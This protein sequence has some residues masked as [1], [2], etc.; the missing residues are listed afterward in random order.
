MDNEGEEKAGEKSVEESAPAP[1]PS[2]EYFLIPRPNV[3][4]KALLEVLAIVALYILATRLVMSAALAGE[5]L[6]DLFEGPEATIL[7]GFFL[8][9]VVQLIIVV[10]LH[11]AGQVDVRA[12]V[13]SLR[14]K[15]P[16]A[17]WHIALTVA[18]VDI[19]FIIGGWIDEPGRV[20]EFSKFALMGSLVPALDGATQ[21]VIF[22]GFILLRLKR[23]G[24]VGRLPIV[25]SG[26]AFALIHIGY[27]NSFDAGAGAALAPI[28]GTFG[29]GMAW[30]WAFQK[31]NYKL[32]PVLLSHV[33]V[34][35][36][37]QPWLALSYAG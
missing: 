27:G 12:A 25:L 11:A 10:G 1:D 33:L 32:A 3:D 29:L 7:A 18:A 5:A 20:V 14:E 36:V 28:L 17:G 30:A 21:E 13:A 24:M 34:I 22:R 37:L 35:I 19:I 26:L 15:A 6:Q 9:A 23:A 8:G 31:S 2:Q 4:L 16:A